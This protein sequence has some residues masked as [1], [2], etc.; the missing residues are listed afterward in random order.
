MLKKSVIITAEIKIRY[1][2]IMK[3]EQQWEVYILLFRLDMNI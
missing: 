1:I 2:E 3:S